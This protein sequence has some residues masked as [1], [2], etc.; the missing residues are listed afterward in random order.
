M[1]IIVRALALVVVI[2]GAAAASL[3]SSTTQNVASRQ[4]VNARLPI[5]T[6]G[7]TVPTC[8]KDPNLQR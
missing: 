4:A 1:K 8:P 7:P 6:C 5:P 3:S 2:A